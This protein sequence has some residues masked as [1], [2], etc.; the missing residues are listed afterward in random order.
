M[1]IHMESAQSVDLDPASDL[2][3]LAAIVA[4]VP[5]ATFRVDA[6]G[7]YDAATAV[8]FYARRGL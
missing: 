7:G 4:R 3:A 2:A 8:A 6:N 1:E 5:D